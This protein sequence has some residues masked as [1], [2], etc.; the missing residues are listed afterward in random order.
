MKI[1]RKKKIYLLNFNKKKNDKKLQ[2]LYKS[3]DAY[4]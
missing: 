1:N 2:F 4:R 3:F